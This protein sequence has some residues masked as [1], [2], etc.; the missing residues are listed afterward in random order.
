MSTLSPLGTS[1]PE[2]GYVSTLSPLGTRGGVREYS[3][4]ARYLGTRGVHNASGQRG[5]DVNATALDG[6]TL[7][8]HYTIAGKVSGVWAKWDWI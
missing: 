5:G 4:P 3:E 8:H 1:V 7:L 2:E 6:R